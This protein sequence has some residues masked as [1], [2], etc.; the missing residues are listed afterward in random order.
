MLWNEAL[1]CSP[2]HGRGYT[3]NPLS[4]VCIGGVTSQ[5]SSCCGESTTKQLL[6]TMWPVLVPP[7]ISSPRRR[8]ALTDRSNPL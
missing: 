2:P 7:E 6:V 1:V 8:R 5:F 3:T 4:C